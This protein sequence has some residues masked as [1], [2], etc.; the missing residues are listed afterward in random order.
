GEGCD[1]GNSIP[2]DGCEPNCV[3]TGCGDGIVGGAEECDDGNT[4]NGD[5]CSRGCRYEAPGSACPS[6]GNQCTDD[7]CDTLGTCTH[8]LTVVSC[9]DGSLCTRNDACVDGVCVGEPVPPSSCR[10]PTL[11]RRGSVLLRSGRLTWVWAHGEETPPGS[12]GDPR[13]P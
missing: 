6:D 10:A 7:H 9:D 2:G 8:A 4:L 3:P 13:L 5:C 11:A 12:F 1:D